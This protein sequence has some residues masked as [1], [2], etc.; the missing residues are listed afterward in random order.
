MSALLL[1]PSPQ[2][3]SE[4]ARKL[5]T[6]A[7]RRRRLRLSYTSPT[8]LFI[9]IHR[10]HHFAGPRFYKSD[11]VRPLA[12]AH[13]SPPTA[14]GHVKGSPITTASAL[15]LLNLQIVSARPAPHVYNNIPPPRL[16]VV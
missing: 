13:F 15:I 3:T 11:R 8:S 4:Y 5:I 6:P 1:G 10:S 7:P 9:P 12:T 16:V 2:G 14:F